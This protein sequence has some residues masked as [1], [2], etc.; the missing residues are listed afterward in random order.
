M[1]SAVNF[2]LPA[3]CRVGWLGQTA[4][5]K[6]PCFAFWPNK[7]NRTA[8]MCRLEKNARIGYMEQHAEFQPENTVYEETLRM[9]SS[10]MKDEKELEAL[11]R[12]I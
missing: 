10:L 2:E 12:E 1:F 7:A 4:Q 5:A 11:N 6:P 3:K 8:G 9:F